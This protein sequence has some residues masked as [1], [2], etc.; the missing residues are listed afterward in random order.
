MIDLIAVD[1]LS[2]PPGFTY[3]KDGQEM[4]ADT[5]VI[6]EPGETLSLP[7]ERAEKLLSIGAAILPPKSKQKAA[8]SGA[9]Q[10]EVK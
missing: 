10:P 1:K 9:N 5:V 4:V 2:V 3:G 7:E 8:R 6:F